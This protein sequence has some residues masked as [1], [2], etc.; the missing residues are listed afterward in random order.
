MKFK[1]PN[2][3]YTYI[4]ENNHLWYKVQGSVHKRVAQYKSSPGNAG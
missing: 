3:I 4:W 2:S 1:I